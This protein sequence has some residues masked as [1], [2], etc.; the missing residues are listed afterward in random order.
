M[1]DVFRTLTSLFKSVGIHCKVAWDSEI[2]ILS[3]LNEDLEWEDEGRDKKETRKEN[4]CNVYLLLGL[5]LSGVTP[6]GTQLR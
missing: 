4:I 6:P 5:P 1:T 3:K 2:Q